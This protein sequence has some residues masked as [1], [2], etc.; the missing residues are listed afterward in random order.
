M[1]GFTDGLE[2]PDDNPLA[3]D[4]LFECLSMTLHPVLDALNKPYT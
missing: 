3:D 1:F 4:E 2:D